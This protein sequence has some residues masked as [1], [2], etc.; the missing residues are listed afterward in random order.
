M[1]QR[2]TNPTVK[3]AVG[4][5]RPKSSVLPEG[6]KWLN[7][8]IPKAVHAH[9]HYMA[10]LS[11]MS[12]KEYVAWFL[13]TARP[14]TEADLSQEMPDLPAQSTFPDPGCSASRSGEVAVLESPNELE[15]EQPHENDHH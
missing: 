7:V 8:P 11:N 2:E 9:A 3:G 13:R 15:R 1:K 14:C 6:F 12:L 10:G 4:T 5:T